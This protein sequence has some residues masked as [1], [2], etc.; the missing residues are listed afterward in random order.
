MLKD[1]I[2]LA[3]QYFFIRTLEPQIL[4]KQEVNKE[5]CTRMI[6]VYNIL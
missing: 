6:S 1:H 2:T 4:T 5:Q 3:P